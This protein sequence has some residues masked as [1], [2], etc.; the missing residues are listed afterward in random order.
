MLKTVFLPATRL[1]RNPRNPIDV[2]LSK[3]KHLAFSGGYE[4][5]LLRCPQNDICGTVLTRG[6]ACPRTR[7]GM[8]EGLERLERFEPICVVNPM[9]IGRA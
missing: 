6:R 5:E 1:C 9:K 8:K 7:S 3:A 2:M 4:V